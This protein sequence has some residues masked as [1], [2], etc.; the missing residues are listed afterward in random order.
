MRLSVFITV[1][2]AFFAWNFPVALADEEGRVIM[3]QIMGA[4]IDEANKEIERQGTV[5]S[6]EAIQWKEA[7]IQAVKTKKVM[8]DQKTWE[9][10]KRI[11]PECN[12]DSQLNAGSEVLEKLD[13]TA[14]DI[15]GF[16]NFSPESRNEKV[17]RAKE[18]ANMP[19]GPFTGGCALI[20]DHY[21]RTSAMQYEIINE[22]N[23]LQ[24]DPVGYQQRKAKIQKENIA[25][26][27]EKAKFEQAHALDTKN[28]EILFNSYVNYMGLTILYEISEDRV[29]PY[30]T[31]K[32]MADAKKDIAYIEKAIKVASPAID[33][34]VVWDRA[35][36]EII[37]MKK[38]VLDVSALGYSQEYEETARIGIF[39]LRSTASSLREE[40]EGE[41]AIEKDF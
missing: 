30:V 31:F 34:G 19:T 11:A 41:Q 6:K 27:K 26:A 38:L 28:E 37:P 13:V 7:P 20:A 17:T 4:I 23:E 18:M 9:E 12:D 8:P 21:T 22:Q 14:R 25:K 35:S 36:K 15:S 24:K 39:K 33:T 2:L 10:V 3:Q 29:F 40:I 5:P 1:T 32:Q 16:S